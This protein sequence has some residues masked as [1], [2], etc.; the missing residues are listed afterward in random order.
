[1]TS[2]MSR[3]LAFQFLALLVV[4]GFSSTAQADSVT[5]DSVIQ[6][7]AAYLGVKRT[8]VELMEQFPPENYWYV[9]VGRSPT[10]L[11]AFFENLGI[12]S[13]TTLPLSG[14]GSFDE[15][16]NM[17]QIEI[18]AR[19]EMHLREM[20]PTSTELQG[21]KILLI[22]YASRGD[23][24]IHALREVRSFVGTNRPG[25]EVQAVGLTTL[26]TT[27][28][29]LSIEGIHPLH[30]DAYLRGNLVHD[31]YKVFSKFGSWHAWGNQIT[32]SSSRKEYSFLKELT[33]E[34]MEEDLALPHDL[35]AKWAQQF[36]TQESLHCIQSALKN[37][38]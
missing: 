3:V 36:R 32:P 20:L 21:R 16:K 13:L 6:A 25:V 29:R 9:G 37:L 23:G 7:R 18:Q 15:P 8:S 2:L 33:L 34:Q 22:D 10:P 4:L 17:S 35:P 28:Q 38:H 12:K 30:V 1:M 19:L 11:M 27:G 26:S 14:M 5:Y 24:I 31:T